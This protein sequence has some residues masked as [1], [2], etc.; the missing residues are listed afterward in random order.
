MSTKTTKGAKPMN[1]NN[2][3][4]ATR[5]PR[6]S[7]YHA[8]ARGTG[9]AVNFELHPATLE[10]EGS[11]LMEIAAQNS[12]GKVAADGAAMLPR[13]DWGEKI[14]VRLCMPDL[15][16]LLQVLRGY[17]ESIADGRGLFHRTMEANIKIAFW[18]RIDPIPGYV[19][20]VYAKPHDG[21]ERRASITFSPSEAVGLCCA[22]E[23]SMGRVAFGV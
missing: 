7:Y 15:C 13:F 18:H 17:Y 5:R 11:I 22:I 1:T 12:P 19:L 4:T 8:N 14:A 3:N 2:N 21:D 20:E 6:L 16:G 23:M 9:A 10:A